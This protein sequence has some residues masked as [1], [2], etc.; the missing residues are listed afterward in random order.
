MSVVLR[1]PSCGT[2]KATSGECEACHESDVRYFCTNHAP[3]LWLDASTCPSCRA[4]F[5]DPARAPRR[6][7]PADS[8]RARSAAPMRAPASTPP[9]A[10]YSLDR[11]KATADSWHGRKRTRRSDAEELEPVPL[12]MTLIHKLIL[13]AATRARHMS[14]ATAAVRERPRTGRGLGGCLIRLVLVMLFL[15]LALAAAAFM[16]GQ[17]LLQGY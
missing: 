7:P 14:P 6:S 4:Q 5:G 17:A 10:P 1:C 12:R 11:P 13:E 9:P 16:F 15:F 8:V 3:G 2:T